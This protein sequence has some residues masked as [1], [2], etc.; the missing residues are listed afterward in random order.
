M[1]A[2]LLLMAALAWA[3]GRRPAAWL[4]LAA[5]V[6]YSRPAAAIVRLGRA[7]PNGACRGTHRGIS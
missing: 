1:K 7:G 4:A 3:I 6:G 2:G 5:V